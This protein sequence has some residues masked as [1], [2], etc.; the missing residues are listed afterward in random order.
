[1][2]TPDGERSNRNRTV[3][4]CLGLSR[5]FSWKNRAIGTSMVCRTGWLGDEYIFS[6]SEDFVNFAARGGSTNPS[7]LHTMD[8]S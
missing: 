4:I 7:L 6:V 2:I 1:M 5:Q 8:F 3:A